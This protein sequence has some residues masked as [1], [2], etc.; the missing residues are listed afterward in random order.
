MVLGE[1][2]SQRVGRKDVRVGS[3]SRK[4]PIGRGQH[5]NTCGVA[6][7]DKQVNAGR[8]RV[9][10]TER[11]R[12]KM[13][14]LRFVSCALICCRKEGSS[15]IDPDAVCGIISDFYIPSLAAGGRSPSAHLSPLSM[16][17]N[18]V[19]VVRL[20]GVVCADLFLL[21]TQMH[22]KVSCTVVRILFVLIKV[23]RVYPS[24]QP[25]CVLCKYCF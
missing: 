5:Y 21:L 24:G 25:Q 3:S 13:P 6:G 9:G 18:L 16:H 2:I 1:R 14:A 17:A 10:M 15:R 22:A 23:N 12:S 7:V 19:Y 8:A 20:R 11:E 4:V